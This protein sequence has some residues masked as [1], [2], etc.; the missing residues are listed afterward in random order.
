MINKYLLTAALISATATTLP[1]SLRAQIPAVPDQ[2]PTEA[3]D[4]LLHMLPT[5]WQMEVT[6]YHILDDWN[7][8]YLYSLSPAEKYLSRW[9]DESLRYRVLRYLEETP[10]AEDFVLDHLKEPLE[11]ASK[12]FLYLDIGIDGKDIWVH[13]VR[14]IS[15]LEDAA[16]SEPDPEVSMA[17]FN[18][19]HM[20][21][22]HRLQAVI[23]KRLQEDRF[24][25]A[26]K[27]GANHE[28]KQRLL[29]EDHTVTLV[30]DGVDLPKFL[31]E[32]PTVFDVKPATSSIRAVIIGDFGTM[33]GDHENQR[34]VAE[35]MIAYNKKEPF[36]FGMT[37][38]DN[39]YF[40][41]KSPTDPLWKVD[42]DDLYGPL[43]IVFYPAFG[44]H[45]WDN[46]M[47]EIEL[48]HSVVNKN[49]HFP[50]P[51][52]TY[53]AGP[54][55]FFVINTGE[56]EKLALDQA[57]LDWLKTELDKSQAK[58]KV[59]YGHYP[60]KD[61]QLGI[62]WPVFDRLM[63]ILKNRA[64]LYIAGH[65]HDFEHL[66]PEGG[67]NLMVVSSAGQ[68][69]TAVPRANPDVIY[70]KG[71]RANGFAVLEANDHSL[72]MRFVDIDGKQL[73]ETTLHK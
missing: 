3:K 66:T 59:V 21:E 24:A 41:M 23:E 22:A 1:T 16:L 17:A 55:Q 72:T 43:G 62:R 5:D 32:P 60:L 68:G 48:L 40:K 54:V 64:D 26:S 52:Y 46:P 47:A 38:G 61:D 36:D 50:A 25:S 4:Q 51:Y 73:Y 9:T 34:K 44:N 7:F 10:G 33:G 11:P 67:V 71:D 45:D 30:I 35:T 39:F 18:A 58:W 31:T 49:W 63:P 13:N 69:S 42:F 37:V 56:N 12:G 8:R 53:T 28:E 65:N 6:R 70:A 19:L 14:V 2:L 57:Q 27:E 15:A 20:I 29:N